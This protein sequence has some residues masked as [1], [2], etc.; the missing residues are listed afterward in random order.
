[1]SRIPLRVLLLAFVSMLALRAQVVPDHYIIEL[2]GA[3][4][5]EGIGLISRSSRSSYMN[6]RRTAVRSRQRSMKALLARYGARTY[7]ST[8]TAAN[9]LLV[10]LSDKLVARLR[11][12][13]GVKRVYPVYE[14][15]SSLNEALA[16]HNV[17]QAWASLGGSDL[18]GAGA[19]IAIID[20]GID[21]THAGFQDTSL[22]IPEGFPRGNTDADL[23]YTSNKV[24]VARSYLSLFGN[25]SDISPRDTWGHGTGVAMI[26]AGGPA[27]SPQGPISGVAPKAFLGSYNVFRHSGSQATRTDVVLK[28]ID[29]AIADGMDVI[30]L[31]LGSSFAT[32]PD[33]DLFATIAERATSAGVLIVAAAGNDGPLPFTM[34]DYAVAPASIAVGATSNSRAFAGKVQLSNGRQFAALPGGGPNSA[35]PITGTFHDVAALDQNGR[36]CGSLPASSLTGEIAFILRGTCTFE[37]KLR[38]AQTAGAV[39]ALVYT[40]D[41][42]PDPIS[43]SVGTATLPAAMVGHTDGLSIKESIAS[44]TGAATLDFQVQ[45]VALD[46]NRI[47]GFSATGPGT[48][49]AIKP[50]MVATGFFVL[51]AVPDGRYAFSSGTSFSAPMVTGA[52]AVLKS[53]R[54]GYSGH[55]YRSLLINAARPLVLASGSP[56]GVQQAGAGVL[57]LESSLAATTTAYPTSLSFGT[58]AGNISRSVTISNLSTTA[59][60][61]SIT[62]QPFTGGPAPIV[63]PASI[64]VP[65]NDAATI[66]ASMATQGASSGTYDGLIRIRPASGRAEIHVPYWFAQPSET[67]RY[68]KV[69][70]QQDVRQ[71]GS[72]VKLRCHGTH[73]G[74]LGRSSPERR[75]EGHGSF[76]RRIGLFSHVFRRAVSR[77]LSNCRQTGS[78]R[79]DNVFRIEAGGLS[80]E[81]TIEA[82]VP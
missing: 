64:V 63:L 26:A 69:V 12:A 66:S 8:D 68:L 16:L 19:R 7:G 35:L 36:A 32:R 73:N 43:M 61:Y 17:P 74:C 29:D 49:F 57:N 45:L 54:P 6:D 71:S 51:S 15:R 56:A 30:N 81:V 78:L 20:T 13:P 65:A 37:V 62:V 76:R 77:T 38:N 60:T 39:A 2:Q 23:A 18:A 27:M 52:A 31:S 46:P 79:G 67:A 75:A 70:S 47:A 53:A 10:R 21:H 22:A 14:I 3:P 34:S 40:T 11:S 55:H 28:A 50:D 48:S 72:I 9:S 44:G 59:E 33:D 5:S 42:Q 41:E 4:A 82:G 25:E 80:K 1:M 24:I 58:A